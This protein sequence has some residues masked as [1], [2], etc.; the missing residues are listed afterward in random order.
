MIFIE[1]RMNEIKIGISV[2]KKQYQNRNK[3]KEKKKHEQDYA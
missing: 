2:P 1:S 3:I